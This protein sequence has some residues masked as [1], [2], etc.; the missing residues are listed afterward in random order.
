MAGGCCGGSK[1]QQASVAAP[2]DA[3]MPDGSVVRVENKAQERVERDKVWAKQR[4]QAR[5]DGYRVS[6]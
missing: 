4:A 5:K 6:R 1:A 3:T 2:Y